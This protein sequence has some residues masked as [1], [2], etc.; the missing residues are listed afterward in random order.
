MTISLRRPPSASPLK[1]QWSECWVQYRVANCDAQVGFLVENQRNSDSI[2]KEI[3]E[4]NRNML[5]RHDTIF[6]V[7]NPKAPILVDN[8][9]NGVVPNNHMAGNFDEGNREVG[10]SETIQ[11]K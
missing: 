2:M 11:H 6:M 8:G 1:E 3:V 5:P 7:P 10:I 4:M 9:S